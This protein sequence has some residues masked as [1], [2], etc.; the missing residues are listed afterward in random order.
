ME[1]DA[2]AGAQREVGEAFG[3]A[4]FLRVDFVEAEAAL[5]VKKALARLGAHAARFAVRRHQ[6]RRQQHVRLA[7]HGHTHKITGVNHPVR[8]VLHCHLTYK[9]QAYNIS[10]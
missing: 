10:F 1:G 8:R 6:P 9:K 7:S 5:C 2:S 3:A 4:V